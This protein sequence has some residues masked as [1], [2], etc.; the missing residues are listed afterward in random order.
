MRVYTRSMKRTMGSKIL[1]ELY[2]R[3]GYTTSEEL[4]LIFKVCSKTIRSELSDLKRTA[5]ENGIEINSARGK[6]YKLEVLDETKFKNYL[7]GVEQKTENKK[8]IDLDIESQVLYHLLF[9]NHRTINAICNQLYLSPSSLL[10]YVKKIQEKMS[11][12]NLKIINIKNRGFL[13]EGREIEKRLCMASYMDELIDYV[14]DRRIFS[15]FQ[16]ENFL[17]EIDKLV[18]N[19]LIQENYAISYFNYSELIKCI[20]VSI[21]EISNGKYIENLQDP[22][23]NKILDSELKIANKIAFALENK[24]F[25][26]FNSDEK[27]FLAMQLLGK[28]S[29]IDKTD[30]NPDKEIC[31]MV[32][33]LLNKIK[34]TTGV[35][36]LDDQELVS[37]LNKHMIPLIIRTKYGIKTENTIL[38]DIKKNCIY[39]YNLAAVGASELSNILGVKIDENEVGFIALYFKIALDKKENN[40]KKTVL[41][42]SNLHQSNTN[43]Y[44]H[45]IQKKFNKYI[46]VILNSN[47]MYI[48]E[49]TANKFDLILAIP[50]VECEIPSKVL[51]VNGVLKLEDMK[52]IERFLSN[53]VEIE[54]KLI[55]IIKKELY[56][57]NIEAKDKESCLHEICTRIKNK[58][59]IED[60][61]ENYVLYR[62]NFG[63]TD[64]GDSI[65]IPHPYVPLNV[66]SFISVSILKTAIDWG[67]HKVKVVLLLSLNYLDVQSTRFYELLSKLLNSPIFVKEIT[68]NKTYN[69]LIETVLRIFA[70]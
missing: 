60:N 4:A 53:E 66:D 34:K 31:D 45:E 8:F 47:S 18:S 2:Q 11:A 54:N 21:D 5:H 51:R 16:T 12:Y 57:T 62:E 25:V 10:Y 64:F 24:F 3:E 63:T 27:L 29:Y 61:F 46:S 35:D 1:T 32:K 23:N 15:N 50:E 22:L 58:I 36:F 70:E 69:H 38:K 65:A 56:F 19:I 33:Q 68:E 55:S 26:K 30:N 67:N 20:A 37:S 44:I 42:I 9:G 49:H 59:D 7:N 41:F 13:V 28:K 39:A 14:K 43:L 48:S 6:G 40:H 17:S 52:K